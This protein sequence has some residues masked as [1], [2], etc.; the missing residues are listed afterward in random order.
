M[1]ALQVTGDSPAGWPVGLAQVLEGASALPGGYLSAGGPLTG[2]SHAPVEVSWVTIE[3]WAREKAGPLGAGRGRPYRDDAER[4]TDTQLLEKLRGFGIELDRAGLE[5]LCQDALSAQEVAS[6]LT[7]R[8]LSAADRG[9]TESDWVWLAVL[10]LWQRWWPAKPC[11]ETVDDKIQEGYERLAQ[12]RGAATDSWLDAWAD[13]LHLCDA[14][15]ITTIAGFDEQ[16]P[17][18]QSLFNWN[19]DLEM[20]L[21]NAGLDDPA[22]LHAR[23]T[24]GEEI[25]HRFTD[26]DQLAA[27]NWRRAIAE[28]WFW[29]RETSK[30]D[31]LY[32]GWLD[33]DPQWGYGWIGWASGYMPPPGTGALTDY[34]RAE[35]LLRQGYAVSGVRDRD[36]VSEWLQLAREKPDRPGHA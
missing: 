10:T 18:T 8:H 1:G 22:K 5:A 34:Q 7:S 2:D 15:G 20:E 21:G 35:D 12:E 30:A 3:R 24:V 36:A 32:R 9:T 31:Q 25:A 27:E 17:L 26:C 14:A 29:L 23:I 6:Q 4:L 13:V 19:Q 16:F 28:A 11:L 33:A